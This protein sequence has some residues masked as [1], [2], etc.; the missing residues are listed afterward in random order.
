[1]DTLE[2]LE[3]AIDLMKQAEEILE[4]VKEEN[5]SLDD[6]YGYSIQII[7]QELNKFSDNSCGY[8]GSNASLEEIIESEGDNWKN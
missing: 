6:Y 1:M 8:I 5:Q 3:E 2:K 4:S 7:I